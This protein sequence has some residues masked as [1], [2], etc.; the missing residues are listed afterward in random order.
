VD[1]D[2][3]QLAVGSAGDWTG[4]CAYGNAVCCWK[5]QRLHKILG[6]Y[7]SE[8]YMAEYQIAGVGAGCDRSLT[9]INEVLY[10]NGARG[11]YAYTGGTPSR[12]GDRIAPSPMFAPY[13]TVG[14]TDGR[15][16]YLSGVRWDEEDEL[17]VYDTVTGLW[18]REDDTRVRAFL[19][20]SYR[21]HFLDAEGRLWRIEEQTWDDSTEWAAEF[22]PIDETWDAGKSRLPVVRKYY[23][24]L[25]LRLDMT[26]NSTVK[27]EVKEDNGAWRTVHA[28]DSTADAA[29]RVAILPRRCD[30]FSVRISGRGYVVLRAMTR[31]FL[32]GSERV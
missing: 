23:V 15:R 10:Y 28:T 4:I 17:L 3:Y 11:V 31:E 1:T 9:I 2:S 20:H 5:E 13:G 29:K 19:V 27:V 14:G 32:T 6:S 8:Y 7:P 30:R 24:R 18:I 16:W 21:L 22:A 26:E 25:D 12:I